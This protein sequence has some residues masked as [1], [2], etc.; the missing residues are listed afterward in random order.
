MNN[1]VSC[2]GNH[3]RRSTACVLILLIATSSLI[4]SFIT[5]TELQTVKPLESHELECTWNG[6]AVS[7]CHPLLTP[8]TSHEQPT[9]QP[10][11]KHPP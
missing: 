9:E 1:D 5:A 7:C 8:S 10:I 4:H 6:N 2:Q 3:E 11:N